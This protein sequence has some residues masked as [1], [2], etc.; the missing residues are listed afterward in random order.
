L[1]KLLGAI[2][3]VGATTWVGLGAAQN[4]KR[5]ENMLRAFASAMEQLAARLSFDLA[6]LP[7]VISDLSKEG[8]YL[9]QSFFKVCLAGLED[10][11]S[12]PFS[13]IWERAVKTAAEGI[14]EEGKNAL[15]AAGA[16]IGRYGL[17]AQLGS[18]MGCEARLRALA[19]SAHLECASKS[20]MYTALGV[21]SG[22]MAV[23]VLI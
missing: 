16:I 15:C 21:C 9:T 7:Q 4:L 2:I 3:L 12:S 20:K 19:D 6:M 10:L 14:G 11:D 8:P 22:L 18:L 17:E 13:Q 1:I 5:R 23:I